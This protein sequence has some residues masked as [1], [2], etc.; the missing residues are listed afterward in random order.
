MS[1]SWTPLKQTFSILQSRDPKNS[2]AIVFLSTELLPGSFGTASV[3][4]TETLDHVTP[5]KQD[6]TPNFVTQTMMR[7]SEAIEATTSL[8]KGQPIK[9]GQSAISEQ[10]I[11]TSQA[12]TLKQVT[13]SLLS[14]QSVTLKQ[15]TQP[16]PSTRTTPTR[17]ILHSLSITPSG[18]HSQTP[19][20]NQSLS[21]VSNSPGTG[22]NPHNVGSKATR[23]KYWQNPWSVILSILIIALNT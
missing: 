16:L 14:D 4:Q 3:T 12:V 15:V 7:T 20:L 8:N 18:H 17:L 19:S 6:V 10:I 1:L 5:V 13:Q 2:Q 11:H 23:S 22:Q 21:S 9:H